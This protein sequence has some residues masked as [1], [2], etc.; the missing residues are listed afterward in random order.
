MKIKAG[1]DTILINIM[2][3]IFLGFMTAFCIIPFFLVISGSFSDDASIIMHGY[4]FIPKNLS[5]DAYRAIFAMPRLIGNA[6]KVTLLITFTGTVIALFVVTTAAYVMSRKD[7]PFRNAMAFYFYF[8]TLF[9]GGLVA[10]YI[11]MIRYYQMK[12]SMLALIIPALVNPFYILIMRNFI[13][14]SVHEALIE[15]ARIDGAGDFKI[16]LKIVTPLL[17]PA[18]A[19]IGLF[20]ALG[21]WNDWYNAMLFL[22]DEKLYPLQYVLYRILTQAQ[23]MALVMNTNVKI[24][25]PKETIKLALTIV[26]I[27][28]IVLAYPFVQ[29]YFVKGLTIGAVKG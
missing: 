5:L 13:T 16:Y 2:G 22:N 9:S 1:I 20:I 10:Y 18:L 27:G 3:V 23:N 4:S 25:P 28:P 11:I 12:N 26:T 15:S 24:D 29:K 17:T 8:T 7:F 19:T 21:Y 14:Q 6:Y